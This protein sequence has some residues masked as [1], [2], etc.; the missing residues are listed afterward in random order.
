MPWKRAVAI[1]ITRASKDSSES[2]VFN[3]HR[4]DLEVHS[5]VAY[6]ADTANINIY[7]LS[8]DQVKFIQDRRFAE[9]SVE[10]YAGYYDEAGNLSGSGLE[11]RGTETI[12]NGD[13]PSNRIEIGV[14]S[15]PVLFSGVIT[16]A[17]GFTRVPEHITQLFCISK[18][19]NLAT[20]FTQ[21][22]NIPPGATLST[23]ISSMCEDYG[24]NKIVTYGVSG[25]VYD[26]VLK[27]GVTFQDTFL[28]EFTK[29][30]GQN[31]LQFSM[32]T[33]EIQVFP[34]TY[35]DKDAITR[36]LKQR[37]PVKLTSNE[38]IGNPVVGLSSL[39]LQ[40]FMNSNIK[41]GM[42]I[43]I[44]PLLG[45]GL[46][47]N[48]VVSADGGLPLNVD[49]SV[50]R[51]AMTNL[52][53]IDEVIHIGSTHEVGFKTL[54]SGQVGGNTMMGSGETS[55]NDFYRDSTQLPLV[56]RGVNE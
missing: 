43:D 25:S 55:W 16:N 30:L 33:S 9:M 24:F 56:M 4:I 36:M 34:D 13:R 28:E 27:R 2:R 10:V 20:K 8:L 46:F 52:Y 37:E 38:V 42:V 21:M 17:V 12:P 26:R 53:F 29:L 41:P 5:T 3:L 11:H 51:Y 35:A 39:K 14:G 48:G 49:D 31:N 15:L 40:T 54:I 6:S 19:Y 23:A 18:A 32:T 45:S 44:A 50:F 47:V 22:R 7:N 1:K